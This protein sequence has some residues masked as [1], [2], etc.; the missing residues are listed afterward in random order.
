MVKGVDQWA[1]NWIE[2]VSSPM[3]NDKRVANLKANITKYHKKL[4]SRILGREAMPGE[5]PG[6][7]ESARKLVAR[8]TRGDWVGGVKIA[9]ENYIRGLKRWAL[10]SFA[11]VPR[12]EE[13]SASPYYSSAEE[14]GFEGTRRRLRSR[15]Y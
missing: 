2:G 15:I 1:E 8:A 12:Y 3:A 4:C 14:Y 7:E 9:K 6:I 10:G 13:Y 5:C 11:E